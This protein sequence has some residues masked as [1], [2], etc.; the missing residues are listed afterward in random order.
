[1]YKIILDLHH[2]LVQAIS[3][4]IEC[5]LTMCVRTCFIAVDAMV[6]KEMFVYEIWMMPDNDSMTIFK[7]SFWVLKIKDGALKNC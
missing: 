1:M 7:N 3:I 4:D 5:W 2:F 6:S